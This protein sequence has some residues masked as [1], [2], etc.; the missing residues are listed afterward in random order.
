MKTYSLKLIGVTLFVLSVLYFVIRLFNI[1]DLPI[2]TDEAIYIR[3][4]QIAKDDASWRFISLTDGKQPSFVWFA[5]LLLHV[6]TDPLLA[7]RLVSV[8]SGFLTVIGLFFLGKELFKSTRIGLISA[9]LY[10][11]YPMAVVYDR[12]A[13]YDSLVGMFMVWSFYLTVLLARRV[14]LDVA[15]I[16]GMV[17]GG[18]VLTKTNAFFSIYLLPF[19]LLL[20]E[21]K[22]GKLKETAVK[23]TMLAGIA[24]FIGFGIYNILRL[25]PFFHIIEEKNALFVYPLGEW[26]MHPFRFLVGNLSGQFD[27]LLTYLTIPVFA[28]ILLAPVVHIKF[29]REKLV[30]LIWFFLPFVALA[31]FGKTLYPRFI[32]FMTLF[33]LP[34]AAFTIDWLSGRLKNRLLLGLILAITFAFQMRAVF[35]IITEFGTSPIAQSDRNQYSNDWPAGWGIKESSVFFEKEAASGPIFVATQGT[36]GLM[37]TSYEIY[38]SDNKN[39]QLKGYWPIDQTIPEEL[40]AM[41]E[42]KTTYVVFY[43]PCV[44]CVNRFEA[45]VGWPVTEVAR[46]DNPYRDSYMT[47][48]QVKKE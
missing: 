9:A 29:A 37:P 36:F 33:L 43:Q 42:E 26:L 18:G 38:L 8:I 4:A 45:P 28:L 14:R 46:Y 40:L 41:S 48:Y 39:I 23:W 13:L 17:I 10:V 32:F 34:L 6:V 35:G 47:I 25:S 30:L 12:M 20:L 31:L 24:S 3:W 1:L 16:L 19:S 11:V 21:W 44:N 15:L 5:I 22:K 27:W 2:F 7:G